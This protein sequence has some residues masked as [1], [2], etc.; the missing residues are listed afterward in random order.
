ML[1]QIAAIVEE[2][3]PDALLISG[4]I[5]DTAQPSSA[6]QRMFSEAMVKMHD[7]CPNMIIVATAGNHDSS[8]RHE[9][10]R[11][12]WET[13]KVHTIGYVDKEHLDNM[14]VTVPDKGF[15]VAVPYFYSKNQSEDIYQQLLLRV[16]ERNTQG[17]PVVMMAHTTVAGVDFTGHTHATERSIGGI[18]ADSLDTFGAGLRLSRL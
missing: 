10:F 14:I 5:Y 1:S 13:L 18:D 9:I 4:D 16:K 11:L 2:E 17:L 8:A 7:A 12:P 6:T 3:Q 15:V